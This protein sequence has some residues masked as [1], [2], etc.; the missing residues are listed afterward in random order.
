MKVVL[1]GPFVELIEKE[2]GRV[3]QANKGYCSLHLLSHLFNFLRQHK[4]PVP[5]KLSD[6]SS[7]ILCS[8]LA[9]ELHPLHS[10]AI[11]QLLANIG[12]RRTRQVNNL[13]ANGPDGLW[14]L[15]LLGRI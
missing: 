5:D 10:E 9:K 7:P 12:N 6:F 1:G 15:M 4:V 11:G 2:L 8:L 3:V 13:L 14:K